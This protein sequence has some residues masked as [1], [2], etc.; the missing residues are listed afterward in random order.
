MYKWTYKACI[1]TQQMNQIK[2]ISANSQAHFE[3][4]T[5]DDDNHLVN[6]RTS[7]WMEARGIL[8]FLA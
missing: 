4:A 5:E 7:A 1:A 2:G 8:T 6:I 3:E